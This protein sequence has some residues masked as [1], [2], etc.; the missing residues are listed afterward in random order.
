MFDGNVLNGIEFWAQTVV[1]PVS[2]IGVI[3]TI[4]WQQRIA[5]RRATLDM[6]LAQQSNALLLEPRRKFAALRSTNDIA[7]YARS[8]NKHPD[9]ILTIMSV[10][11][12][13]ELIA[14]G[15]DEKTVDEPIYKRYH[16]TEYVHDWIGC[17]PFVMELRD[18]SENPT[19]YCEIEALAKKWAK[20][21]E[22]ERV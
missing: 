19:Y 8:K 13:N 5:K 10:L 1:V 15:I 21:D 2:F 14:I 16:R 6:I 7:K 11:N 3:I 18:Q 20:D 12:F 9:E 4:V 22:R 17:K